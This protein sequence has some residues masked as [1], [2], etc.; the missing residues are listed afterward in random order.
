[1]LNYQ[2]NEGTPIIGV[3]IDGTIYGGISA[4][5]AI[6]NFG[7]FDDIVRYDVAKLMAAFD[8]G[9][10]W[11]NLSKC[12]IICVIEDDKVRAC[13]PGEF[14]NCLVIQQELESWPENI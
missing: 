13:N 4:I 8:F 14:D 9:K 3:I 5:E 6:K 11:Q 12:P 7:R 2:K 10:N 1:M